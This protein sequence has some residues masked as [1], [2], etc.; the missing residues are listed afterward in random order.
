M[1]REQLWIHPC[2]ASA[3]SGFDHY[4]TVSYSWMNFSANF[5]RYATVSSLESW[6]SLRSKSKIASK[7]VS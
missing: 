1:I 2:P 7:S 3:E 6:I 4:L 5:S